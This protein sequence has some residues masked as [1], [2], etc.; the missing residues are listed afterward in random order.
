MRD[1]DW[2]LVPSWEGEGDTVWDPVW[3]LERDPVP[4]VEPEGATVWDADGTPV[5][6]RV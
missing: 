3:E 2:E 5:T 1:P 4:E 6:D